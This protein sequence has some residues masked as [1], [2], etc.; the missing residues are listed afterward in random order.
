MS[1]TCPECGRLF[2]RRRQTH[3]CSPAITLGAYFRTAEAWE[4]AVFEAVYAHLSSLGEVTVEP[5]AVG[6]FLKGTG[7]FAE[8]RPMRRWSAL[9]WPMP[10][11]LTHPRIARKP[12]AAG[13][14]WFHVVNLS[15]ADQVDDQIRDWLTEGWFADGQSG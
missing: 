7:S 14:R 12:Y 9:S 3:E 8:L 4:R 15:S 6:I 13:V 11:R 1:W 10:R 5:V 2:A